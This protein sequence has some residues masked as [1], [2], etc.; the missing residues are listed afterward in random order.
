VGYTNAVL[1][2]VTALNGLAVYQEGTDA[3]RQLIRGAW[4]PLGFRE[5]SSLE[6]VVNDTRERLKEPMKL[7]EAEALVFYPEVTRMFVIMR[8]RQLVEA[9]TRV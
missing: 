2:G 6:Y 7:L 4:G 8:Q 9:M 5:A 3:L 1:K